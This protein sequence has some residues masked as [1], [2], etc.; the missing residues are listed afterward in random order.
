MKLMNYN[1]CKIRFNILQIYFLIILFLLSRSN[2]IILPFYSTNIKLNLQENINKF[3]SLEYLLSEI[4]T[5][6]IFSKI[7]IGNPPKIVEFYL[8][9]DTTIYSVL[10][11][12]CPINSFSSYKPTLSKNFK[13]YS[14]Y[15]I[16]IGSINNAA[17]VEDNCSLYIDLN[18]TK[19]KNIEKFTFLLGNYSSSD[20]KSKNKE[21]FCGKIGLYKSFHPTYAYARNFI[22]FLKEEK[23]IDS[24]SWSVFFFDNEKSYNIN[25]TIQKKYEGFYIAGIRDKDFLNI[26][27][28]TDIISVN[29]IDN[30]INFKIYFYESPY[31]KT[32]I[33]FSDNSLV[34][35]NLDYN[36]I[37]SE[38]EYY[39]K[40]K[41]IFFRQYL[42]K[43]IC[44][45]K[46][47]YITYQG[48]RNMIV[49]DS[50]FKKYLNLF[51][52]LYFNNR[53]LSF[54]FNLDYNDL[55]L[56]YEDKI[57][58]LIVYKEMI[59]PI[60]TLGKI[61]MKKY[62]LIFDQDKK[63]ISFVYLGKFKKKE[64][65]IKKE[66]NYVKKYKE[67]CVYSLL[68]VGIIIGLLL[69]RRF[70]NKNRKLKANELEEKFEYIS[71]NINSKII[72]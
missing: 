41:S 4:N 7:E 19:R 2:Y 16:S 66:N 56:E 40:I 12:F 45:E 47:S 10:S 29:A 64:N 51:P 62:P 36:Y 17:L 68:F 58:F 23:I 25:N 15:T 37:I 30:N 52:T 9:M 11:N 49:C 71:N 21:N 60:W 59:H 3:N 69:G 57:Y 33:I 35:F 13:N 38:K 67:Y 26:F 6:Q 63:T 22:T 34:N 24:Y 54:I 72:E 39:E 31:N 18:L 50:S 70:W 5:N 61:F 46:Y 32:E 55:F 14:D 53:E 20:D 48:K 1:I 28:T 43:K 27:K 44:V 42:D 8:S 65:D